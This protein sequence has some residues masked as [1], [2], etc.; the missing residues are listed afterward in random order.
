MTIQEAIKSGKSFKRPG[1][2]HVFTAE[3]VDG[4]YSRQFHKFSVEDVLSEE[5]EIEQQ[6]IALTADQ[7][8]NAMNEASSAV[9]MD[10]QVS[11]TGT[12]LKKL[13]F[14]P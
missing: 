12:L 7:I 11:W 10:D 2:K 9:R 8:L 14:K 6:E 3:E 4:E 13:G 1:K 5:W